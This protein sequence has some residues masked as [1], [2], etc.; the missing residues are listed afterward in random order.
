MDKVVDNYFLLQRSHFCSSRSL[1]LANC[2]YIINWKLLQLWS[3]VRSNFL[4]WLI[5]HD[6]HWKGTN[7]TL[8]EKNDHLKSTG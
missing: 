5:Q 1:S 4:L 3:G 8:K 7:I 2:G 6:D